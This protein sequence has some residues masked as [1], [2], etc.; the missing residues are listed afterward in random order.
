MTRAIEMLRWRLYW[1][2]LK[3]LVR[4]NTVVMN[5]RVAGIQIPPGTRGAII[6]GNTITP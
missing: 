1:W 5:A 6:Y 2:L 4:N 3:R